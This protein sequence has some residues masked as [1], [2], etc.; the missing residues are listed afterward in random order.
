MSNNDRHDDGLVHAHNWATEPPRDPRP[1]PRATPA[2]TDDDRDE[3]LVHSHGWAC[4]E[5]GRP[6]H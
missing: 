5:R 4:G 2:P 6:A 1:R 3:G